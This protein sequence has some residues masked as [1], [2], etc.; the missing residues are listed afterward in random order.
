VE[1][2]EGRDAHLTI[3]SSGRRCCIRAAPCVAAGRLLCGR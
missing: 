2:V 3:L 1:V